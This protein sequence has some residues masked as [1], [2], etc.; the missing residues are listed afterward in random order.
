MSKG[1]VY[2]L[3]DGLVFPGSGM[4]DRVD[5]RLEGATASRWGRLAQ[6]QALG[7]KAVMAYNAEIDTAQIAPVPFF[8]FGGSDHDAEQMQIVIDSPRVIWRTF[9]S[10]A[11][12]N[13][14]NLSGEYANYEAPTG[15]FPGTAA[16]IAWPSITCML[17]W[18]TNTRTRAIVDMVNGAKVN[19]SASWVRAFAVIPPDTHNAPGT[20]AAYVLNAF[21][22]PGWPGPSSA[23]R[24]I[25]LGTVVAGDASGVFVIPPFAKRAT[26]IGFSTASPP[27]ITTGYLQFWQSPDGSNNVGNYFISGN[28]P[29]PFLV[30]NGAAYVS[31]VSGMAADTKFAVLF[32]LFA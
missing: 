25:Q 19:L 23:T 2:P 24:T 11:G 29:G 7:K 22:S 21:A 31:I 14:Q 5:D 28:Q 13:L 1:P 30:P 8:D 17:E 12:E 6:G 27:E 15:N 4:P 16:P 26:L 3:F 32:D 20:S 10:L 9:A 18:G